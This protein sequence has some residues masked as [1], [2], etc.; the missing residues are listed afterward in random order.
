[1]NLKSKA[2]DHPPEYGKNT[3]KQEFDEIDPPAD[4][5]VIETPASN[6]PG[7]DLPG[8]YREIMQL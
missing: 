5:P 1:M 6:S 3:F 4:H 7:I 2:V 8:S